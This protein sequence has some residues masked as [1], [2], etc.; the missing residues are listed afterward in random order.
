MLIIVATSMMLLLSGGVT[1]RKF[2]P[3]ITPPAIFESSRKI[4]ELL[5]QPL[6][7]AEAG[8]PVLHCSDL[9]RSSVGRQS[10]FPIPFHSIAQN[11]Q[12]VA[13][14][15]TK[16]MS[17]VASSANRS[18]AHARRGGAASCRKETGIPNGQVTFCTA[19]QIVSMGTILYMV[20][21]LSVMRK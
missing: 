19:F 2:F 21:T 11:A 13:R 6:E 20:R 3:S 14:C 9:V 18:P 8:P 7:A 12:A 4:Y 16:T 5:R 1:N 15:Y 10:H 17:A